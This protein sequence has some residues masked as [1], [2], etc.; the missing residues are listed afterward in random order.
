MTVTDAPSFQASQRSEMS[1]IGVCLACEGEKIR[2]MLARARPISYESA[3]RAIGPEALDSWA[4]NFESISGPYW[5]GLQLKG[6]S[7]V[8]FYRSRY[9]VPPCV[10]IVHQR[11]RHIFVGC[12]WRFPIQ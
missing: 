4:A 5:R 6:N 8:S 7:A 1:Y 9:D 12:P 3:Q 11:L 10:Y 2:G